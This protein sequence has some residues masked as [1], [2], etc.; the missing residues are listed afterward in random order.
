M[1]AEI[2]ELPSTI[3][4]TAATAIAPHVAAIV[5]RAADAPTIA[6]AQQQIPLVIEYVRGYTR[7]KGFENG[8]IAAPL[9][10]VIQSACARLV[11][12]PEQ[13]SYYS[14]ADYSERPAVLAGWTLAELGVLKRYRITV[15]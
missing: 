12:N 5:G 14:M 11:T 15:A 9:V 6:L 4:S 1:S 3:N 13:L 10:A 2:P 7:G 8:K